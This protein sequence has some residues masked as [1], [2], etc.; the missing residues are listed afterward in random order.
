MGWTSTSFFS[1]LCH[2]VNH[3]RRVSWNDGWSTGWE[4]GC[5]LFLIRRR[6]VS[7]QIVNSRTLQWS[8]RESSC[9]LRNI[10]SCSPDLSPFNLTCCLFVLPVMWHSF[11]QHGLQNVQL[12]G[13]MLL[14]PPALSSRPVS[15]PHFV[16]FLLYSAVSVVA[17]VA[18][19]CL[20]VTHVPITLKL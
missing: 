17:T 18:A 4:S 15:G 12:R 16:W 8:L 20:P 1:V 13:Q 2:R 11:F 14:F 10:F 7:E 19:I 5:I 6:A 9:C 3:W